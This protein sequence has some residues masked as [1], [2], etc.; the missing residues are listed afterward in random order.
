MKNII[1][2]WNELLLEAI[3]Q[4]KPGPPMAARSIAI[5]YT[6]IYDCWAAY[7]PV[8]NMTTADFAISVA[9][10]LSNVETS[11]HFAAYRSLI[12]QYPKAKSTK[13]KT[14]GLFD[15]KMSQL[16]HDVTLTSVATNTAHGVGNKA[17]KQVLTFRQTDNS[18][19]ANNYADTTS[20]ESK[21][22]PIK[23]FFPTSVEEI[24][25]PDRW[26]PLTYLNDENRPATIPYIGPH[27]GIVTPFALTS[28]SQFRPAEPQNI[29]SQGFLDQAK[30]VIDIQANLT[31][32]QKVM[33][34]YWAD[35]PKSEMPPGHWTIFGSFV[36]ERDN[37]DLEKTVKL[38]FVLANAI[39]DASIAVWDAKRA[40]DYCRPI[41]AIRHL[42]RGKTIRAWG[43]PGKGTVEILGENWRTFQ[44]NTFPTPPFAEFVSGHSGFS[45]AAA[46]V[47]K[48]ITNSDHFGYFYMQTKPLAADPLEDVIGIT[49][50][51]DTFT[52]AAYDAGESRLY[53][54]I[55]FYEGNVVGLALGKNVGLNAYEKAEKYWNGLIS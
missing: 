51:W 15:E 11:I 13:D 24:E 36:A 23:P 3:R 26:Q 12:D 22:K 17:A 7:H 37:M 14:L 38:F 30:H 47:L 42:F 32:K 9:N 27:W 44:V 41:T 55:H 18:N 52:E 35:G 21:N 1:I 16:G 6:S 4:T 50:K 5:V 20:Y 28:G 33:A 10:T 31:P 40:Y 39:F 48:K 19:Q 25:H 2:E 8:A 34:E 45:M 54:G 49:M 43:G 46:T 29:N 53:G